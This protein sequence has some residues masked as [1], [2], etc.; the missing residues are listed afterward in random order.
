MTGMIS[1]HLCY[2]IFIRSKSQVLLKSRE[3]HNNFF[4]LFVAPPAAY[5]CSWLGVKSEL[6][7]PA[8]ATATT[9]WIWTTSVTYTTACGITG[10]LTQLG[11]PW[12]EPSSSQTLCQV[13]NALSHNGNSG[14]HNNLNTTGQKY[15][16][17]TFECVHN[18]EEACGRGKT[19]EEVTI[20][21]D[22]RN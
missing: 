22:G 19:E 3:L 4:F 10:S 21:E 11:R 8:Y 13:L 2:L 18:S 16:S 9:K 20:S 15:F 12:I 1:S 17:A 6:Q 14:L 7:L 5:G